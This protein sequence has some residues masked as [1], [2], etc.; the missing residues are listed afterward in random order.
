[1]QKAARQRDI[2]T[3]L[4]ERQCSNVRDI[5]REI[6]ASPAT[7]RRDLREM[8]QAG[9][10]RTFHGGVMP[11]EDRGKEV[12]LL[13]RE[14]EGK[15]AKRRIA[16][17]AAALIPFGASVLMDA[18]STAMYM[19]GF[20]DPEREITVFTNGLRTAAALCE[21][22][23]RTY[24]LGGEVG[25]L[26]MVTTGSL[27]E[28]GLSMIHVDMLFFSSQAMNMQGMITDNSERES[29]LRREMIRHARQSYFLCHSEKVGRQMLYTVGQAGELAGVLSDGDLSG[30][31]GV[32]GILI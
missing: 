10:L 9:L 2:L 1:M 8:E 26:S 24:C 30:I 29:Q 5:C 28:A 11:V 12:P 31:P 4:K 13:V 17:A 27:A 16:C 14:Q 21:R 20:M 15:D 32:R 7:V 18:S 3:L 23:I 22:R 25:P 6:Y 19:A